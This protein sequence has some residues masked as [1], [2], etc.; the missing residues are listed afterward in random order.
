MAPN[1]TSMV[2]YMG[3]S[4]LEVFNRVLVIYFKVQRLVAK[5]EE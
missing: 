5:Y 4:S 3:R 2:N 1:F